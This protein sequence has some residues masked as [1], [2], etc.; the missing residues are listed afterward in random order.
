MYYMSK[1]QQYWTTTTVNGRRIIIGATEKRK[2]IVL[3]GLSS[4][5]GNF[6]YHVSDEWF[7]SYTLKKKLLIKYCGI[8]N[9]WCNDQGYIE[10]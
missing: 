5:D 7:K 10:G 2:D 9:Y 6:V 3:K 8:C 1:G 4:L